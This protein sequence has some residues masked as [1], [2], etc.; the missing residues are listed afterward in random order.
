MVDVF[1]LNI[2]QIVNDAITAAGGLVDGTLTKQ[3]IG[4]R[5]PDNL[6]AGPAVTTASHAFKGFAETRM[7]PRLA[8]GSDVPQSDAVISILGAS[9]APPA[10]PEANDEVTIENT[11]Y[12][13]LS[14]RE[15]D[16]AAALY[17]FNAQAA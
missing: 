2:A 1:G 9:V 14:L 5:D 10:V 3:A 15:R 7:S 13:L 4:Q 8:A 6:T 17:V 11:T 16:P 12:L